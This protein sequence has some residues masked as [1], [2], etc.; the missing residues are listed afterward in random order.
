[1]LKRST[2]WLAVIVIALSP[3]A[4]SYLHVAKL[5]KRQIAALSVPLPPALEERQISLGSVTASTSTVWQCSI[6]NA[7][8]E[9]RTTTATTAT[10]P[11]CFI[12]GTTTRP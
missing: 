9:I 4:W 10:T 3:I 12:T 7:I 2:I 1:M 5:P 11:N 8:S 6:P